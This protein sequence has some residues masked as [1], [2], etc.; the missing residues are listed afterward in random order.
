M[1]LLCGGVVVWWCTHGCGC[2]Y[3]YGGGGSG[4][5]SGTGSGDYGGVGGGGYLQVDY[6][7]HY[8]HSITIFL[9]CISKD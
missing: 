7:I 8:F 3:G 2:S 5:G 6:K 4:G 9:R 1:N